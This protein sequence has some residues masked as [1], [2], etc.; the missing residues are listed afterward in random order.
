MYG[1]ITYNEAE[2]EKFIKLETTE[3][4]YAYFKE[5]I[6]NLSEEEFDDFIAGI[7]NSYSDIQ[8]KEPKL[9]SDVLN[10]V[11]GGVRL[12]KLS[13]QLAT[14]AM[15]VASLFPT[16]A[17]AKKASIINQHEEIS[18]SDQSYTNKEYNIVGKEKSAFHRIKK[19]MSKNKKFMF[20]SIAAVIALGVLCKIGSNVNEERHE[21]KSEDSKE[22]KIKNKSKVTVDK[23]IDKLKDVSDSEKAAKTLAIELMKAH[24]AVPVC[25]KYSNAFHE[26]MDKLEDYGHWNYNKR[27]FEFNPDITD[28]DIKEI[29]K[30]YKS[31]KKFEDTDFKDFDK[32]EKIDYESLDNGILPYLYTSLAATDARRL[33]K[34]VAEKFPTMESDI[35]KY[36]NCSIDKFIKDKL[37]DKSPEYEQFLGGY[38]FK[39]RELLETLKSL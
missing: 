5:K 34:Y 27:A 28:D 30:I 36:H 4:V 13:R 21:A 6:P 17:S 31:Y 25:A 14:G 19:W 20:G 7:L 32:I 33:K 39:V 29:K 2:F 38:Y 24:P 37:S 9:V 12:R 18:K 26:L 23:I 15:A 11:A 22:I 1:E 16:S 3:E 10:Q 8:E 35:Q